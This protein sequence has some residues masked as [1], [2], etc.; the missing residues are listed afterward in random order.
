MLTYL[1][2]EKPLAELEGKIEELRHLGD[3][4]E[5]DIAS[6]VEKLKA[7]LDKTLKTT[8]A[9]LTPWAKGAG[10][11]PPRSSPLHGLYQPPD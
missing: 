3:S 8:Y 9:N 2:F 5:I 4:A 6:E 11:A 10:G 7:K 1:D